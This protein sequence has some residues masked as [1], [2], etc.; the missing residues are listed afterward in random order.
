[1]EEDIPVSLGPPSHRHDWDE[2]YY[3]IDGALD[4][5]SDGRRVHIER[6]DFAYLPRSIAVLPGFLFL[7]RRPIHPRS[8]RM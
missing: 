7:L 4:F 6:G 2:A 1:M 5:E 8:S 3:V